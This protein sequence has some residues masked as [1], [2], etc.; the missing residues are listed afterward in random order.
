VLLIAGPL[1]VVIAVLPCVRR[2][3]W[4]SRRGVRVTRRLLLTP[5]SCAWLVCM[6]TAIRTA[7]LQY[8]GDIQVKLKPG[9]FGEWCRAAVWRQQRSCACSAPPQHL[10]TSHGSHAAAQLSN[11]TSTATR[12]TT[13]THCTQLSAR[14]TATTRSL[15]PP[16][17]AM[18][19]GCLRRRCCRARQTGV[20]CGARGVCVCVNSGDGCGVVAGTHAHGCAHTRVHAWTSTA[21]AAACTCPA[22]TQERRPRGGDA[23]G[24]AAPGADAG[25][26]A[27]AAQAAAAA[28]GTEAAAAAAAGR[29]GGGSA[30]G[31]HHQDVA[32]AGGQRDRVRRRDAVVDWP[33]QV[34]PGQGRAGGTHHGRVPHACSCASN[35]HRHDARTHTH[36]HHTHPAHT[37]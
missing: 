37:G 18:W 21:G 3:C 8:Q 12:P 33:V 15:P 36:T 26:A 29:L 5:S 34:V 16:A 32:A 25:S 14:T 27:V 1:Q 19:R 13:H 23:G 30:G 9:V 28:A 4:C 24:A 17:G 7:S 22:H 11:R 6:L 35:T 31:H 20:L 10:S 2:H